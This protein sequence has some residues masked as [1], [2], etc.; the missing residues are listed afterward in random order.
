LL[1]NLNVPRI[2]DYMASAL[3]ETVH[4]SVGQA[5]APGAKLFDMTVDLSLAAPHDCP[6]ISHYRMVLREKAHLRRLFV[7]PGE[8]AAVGAPLALFSTD[9][10][11]PL[12][13]AP[14]RMA[15]IAIATIMFQS[16]WSVG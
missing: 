15:R 5:L 1:L 9:P 12:D 6:P 10:D 4:A 11:E 7:E 3:I 2:N 14:G 13:A 16:I 8:E